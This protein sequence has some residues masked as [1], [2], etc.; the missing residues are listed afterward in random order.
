MSILIRISAW[1]VRLVIKITLLPVFIGLT[2]LEWICIVAVGF[3]RVFFDLAGGIIILTG[4]LSFYFELE[5]A[6][7]MWRMIAI[8]TGFCILPMIGDTL[9]TLIG[10]LSLLTQRWLMA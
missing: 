3:L 1:L 8:G 9:T 6:S 5:P 10:Y 7:E 4:I 2:L